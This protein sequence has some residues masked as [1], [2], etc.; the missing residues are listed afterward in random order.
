MREARTGRSRWASGG[1]TRRAAVPHGRW[2]SFQSMSDFTMYIASQTRVISASEISVPVKTA[3]G[4]NNR[5]PAA[6]GGSRWRSL[7]TRPEAPAY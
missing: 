3:Q 2:C 5:L 6:K 1:L 4:C 7:F